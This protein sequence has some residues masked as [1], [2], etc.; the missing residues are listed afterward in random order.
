MQ[1]ELIQKVQEILANNKETIVM[2]SEGERT[3]SC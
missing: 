3:S 1:S 2:D